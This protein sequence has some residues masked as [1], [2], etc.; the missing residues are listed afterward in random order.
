M[1]SNKLITIAVVVT[2]LS[3]IAVAA[4]N[5]VNSDTNTPAG[6]SIESNTSQVTSSQDSSSRIPPDQTA[7]P[8]DTDQTRRY[9]TFAPDLLRQPNIQH[10]VLF[11]K[12]DWCSTCNRLD[13]N[14]RTQEDRIPA[15]TVIFQ[16][17]YDKNQAL[18]Q[19]Y[20]VTIQ[21]T[22][23]LVDENGGEIKKW[24]GSRDLD[25]VVSEL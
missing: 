22:L 24:V 16:V 9:I 18:R 10:R 20:G 6:E 11:F 3:I 14:I 23:V 19:Q 4:F 12:A 8:S 17:D 2:A 21:H 15:D 25:A 1:N 7:A 5:Y 13:Q